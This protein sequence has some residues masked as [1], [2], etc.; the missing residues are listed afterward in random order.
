MTTVSRKIK[1]QQKYAPR[2]GFE[3][4]L[5]TPCA[6]DDFLSRP[7]FCRRYRISLRTAEMMAHKGKGPKV[8]HLG[9]RAYYHVEDIAAWCE[10]QREKSAARFASP[11]DV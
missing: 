6:L 8:T 11:G 2:R 7:E 3:H 10:A 9:K 1:A 4:E 5:G